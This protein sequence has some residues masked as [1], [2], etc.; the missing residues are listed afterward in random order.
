[1]L[2]LFD[3]LSEQS[4]GKDDTRRV[5]EVRKAVFSDKSRPPSHPI[6]PTAVPPQ[7]DKRAWWEA[8]RQAYLAGEVRDDD[9]LLDPAYRA[10]GLEYDFVEVL[11]TVREF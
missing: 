5:N 9:L 11:R 4:N 1:M 8:L 10:L 2:R 7:A 6:R 3:Q